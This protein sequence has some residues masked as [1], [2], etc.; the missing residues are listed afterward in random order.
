MP[1]A[2]SPETGRPDGQCSEGVSPGDGVSPTPS[3]SCDDG[4]PRRL[5]PSSGTPGRGAWTWPR[6]PSRSRAASS[7]A[8]ARPCRGPRPSPWPTATPRTAGW[9]PPPSPPGPAGA[10]SSAGGPRRPLADRRRPTP[11]ARSRWCPDPR[12]PGLGGCRRPGRCALGRSVRRRPL[13]PHRIDVRVDD[14]IVATVRDDEVTGRQVGVR[15]SAPARPGTTSRSA[16]D[17]APSSGRRMTAS[18]APPDGSP[19]RSPREHRLGSSTEGCRSGRTDGLETV[20]VSQPPWVQIPHP[21]LGPGRAGSLDR[22]ARTP[23]CREP[24]RAVGA[25][26]VALLARRPSLA[27]C[28]DD[29]AGRRRRP[30]RHARRSCTSVDAQRDRHRPQGHPARLRGRR[31]RGPRSGSS[32]CSALLDVLPSPR[33]RRRG[34]LRR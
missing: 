19:W 11:A 4:Q 22:T 30:R 1:A 21:P 2:P 32:P 10:S 20:V 12:R 25:L 27:G 23:P 5:T 29:P 33:G 8:T 17:P 6:A 13:R 15:A 31:A 9:S 16:P 3:G 24:R 18:A 34:R 26:A 14:A 28:G 7:P